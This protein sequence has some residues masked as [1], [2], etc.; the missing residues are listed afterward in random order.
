VE[1]TPD[2]ALGERRD[3]APLARR[4]GSLARRPV[5]DRTLRVGRGR[6]S[7]SHDLA[8]LLDTERHG[9]PGTRGILET[10]QPRAVETCQPGAAPAP[11]R[12][13]PGPQAA[14]HLVGIGPIREGQD[15]LCAEA[16]VRGR[17]M[18][19]DKGEEGLAF[20][21]RKGHRRRFR[22]WHSRLRETEDTQ[23]ADGTSF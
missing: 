19:T 23:A 4:S 11:P 8:P 7:Q 13:A 5:T 9:G 16:E 17:F 10:F 18:R 2:V 1:K 6:T 22:T 20:G 15:K 21:C 3:H 12:K 14:C